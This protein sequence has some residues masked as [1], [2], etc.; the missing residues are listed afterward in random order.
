MSETQ[1][2]ASA[3]MAASPSQLFIP[4]KS[5][6]KTRIDWLTSYH[7][8]SFGDYRDPARMG[9]GVLRVINDDYIAE[10]AGF[11]PHPHRDMEIVTL[12]FDGALSH[13][14]SLGNA[15]T[16]KAGDVQRMS[17]GTGIEHSE[18]NAS[19]DDPIHLFQIWI[20]PE[21]R[22]LAPSYEQKAFAQDTYTNRWRLVGAKDGR[23]GSVSYHQDVDLYRTFLEP[24]KKVSW[25][26][27]AGRL[28]WLHVAKGAIEVNGQKM[29][30]GDALAAAD[31]DERWEITAQ[32]PSEVIL[33]DQ[34]KIANF[35]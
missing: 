8:F 17:A 27:K 26:T 6:G 35:R 28:A 15:A 1:A 10:G 4:G 14:D 30:T 23:E 12:V 5:R 21:A 24:Q 11:P 3:N 31:L 7:S 34:P 32:E 18:F 16:M 33:F 2:R 20:L 25:Q 13:K 19:A 9:F 22:G 29:E